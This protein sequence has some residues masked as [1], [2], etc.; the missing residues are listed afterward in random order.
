MTEK[1]LELMRR[2][3]QR[4]HEGVVD[5]GPGSR[6]DMFIWS[7]STASVA[8]FTK[9]NDG[10][11]PYVVRLT[12]EGGRPIEEELVGVDRQEFGGGGSN[13]NFEVV[14]KLYHLARSK[15]LNIDATIEG[16]LG[17]LE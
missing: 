8:L 6:A 12:D 7:G 17:E 3:L 5:W 13:P 14:E 2:L 10:F 11:A 15:A 4:T 1:L 9:D 16:L